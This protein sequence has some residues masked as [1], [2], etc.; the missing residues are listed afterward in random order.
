[1][2]PSTPYLLV[3]RARLDANI[4]ATARRADV[5]GVGL[6]PHVKTHKSPEIAQL[7]LDAGAR[8]ITVA[9]VGEAEVFVSHGARDVFIA[10]PLWLDEDRGRRLAAVA[11]RAA[12]SVGVDSVAGAH[13]LALHVHGHALDVLVEVDSG[14][15]R[16]GVAPDDAGRVADA[17]RSAGLRVIGVFTFPGHSY[18][19]EGR[20]EAAEQEASALAVAAAALRRRGHEVLVVSG[21]STPSLDDADS[22]VLTEWRPGVYVFGD[23]QQWELGSTTPDRI[24]LTCQATVVSHAHGRAVVD[25]GSKAL[26]AD[27][28]PWATGYGRVLDE[29]DARIVLLSEHHAAVEMPPGPLPPLGSTMSLV[30]NHVCNAVNLADTLWLDGET[31]RVAWPVAARGRNA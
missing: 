26:G 21:G 10:Y 31:G 2:S 22:V 15:H 13:Q 3:D 23:A 1:M 17:A 12:V 7:Q 30:P 18:L 29:P 14:H 28:A 20:R 25:A 8:G 24:A 27:R 9:T 6:R 16:T 11:E 19:P 5:A 4:A